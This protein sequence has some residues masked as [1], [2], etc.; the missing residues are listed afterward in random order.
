MSRLGN[1]KGINIFNIIIPS[2]IILLIALYFIGGYRKS[3]DEGIFD[4]NKVYQHIKELSSPKYKGRLAGDEGNKLTLQYIE[5]YFKN[6]GIEPAGKNDTYYQYFDTMITHIDLNPY[7]AIESKD[8]QIIEEFEMFKDYKFFT[9]WYGG[10][11]RFK[12]DIVFVDNYLYDVPPQLLKNKLVVMGTFDIRIKDV[13]YVIRNNGKG[14]LFRRTSPYDRQDRELQ[15]QKKVENTIKKGESLFFG[16]LGLEAYNKIKNYSSHELINQGMSEDILVEE[17]LPESVGIIKNVKLKCDINYPVIKTANILGKIDGKAKDK[18]LIIGANIDH[19]GQGMNGKHFPGALNN[20]SGTGMMLEL[21]RV[22]KLQK[23]LPDRTIIFAGWNAKENVAAGSQYYVKNPLSPLEK[24]QV[25]N[26][27]CIGSTVDGEIRFETKGEAGEILRDKIIQ[28]AEDLKDTNNLQIETIKTPVGRWSD[29]MPFIET[30][31]P[32]INIIDG[33]LNLYTYEDNIDNVS[34]EKLKKVGI[35]IINY[36]KREIFKDT[37]ADYLNNI[38]IILIIIFLFGTLFIYMIFSIYKTNGDM[39]ILSISI[40]NIYYSLPFNILLKCFYFIT[41]AFII[42]FS[43]IFIG[44]LPLNFNMVFHNGELYT[45][46]SMYL[47]MKKSILY[48]RNLLLHGF[49]MTE[50]NVEIFRIVLNSTGKSVKLLSFAIVISLILGVVKGMFDSYKGGRRSG[51]RTVGTL[52]A[53]SLPD[54]FIVLCSMLL[55]SYISYSDMIKQLV[56]LSKLKGFFMPLL[57]LSIIPTV[58]ISRITFIVVQEEI[59]KD[60]V[61]AAKGRG[62]SKF[63]IFTRHILKSVVI[64]VVDSIP[65]LITIIISNLIIVE[66]L[67]DYRGIVFNLYRF[68]KQNDINSFIGLSLALGLIYITFIIIAKLISRLINP[69]KREGVN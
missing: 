25:I 39:E 59:K 53:F 19:V 17:E 10:G 16:Y 46:F 56:D 51:L 34:K 1:F 47:T 64:K 5:D 58:Y 60:Y 11:G 15:L 35:V 62:L 12:G 55:I 44:S 31:I 37:L 32:A 61:I 48:I 24:T 9:Y 40:E 22:I 50:N 36:I 69:K 68:Y 29:H 23:N 66:Y 20:A 13:E 57:T 7:F 21:A 2:L 65:A 18:Y 3:F 67:L 38:E 52:M 54:V 63:N 28:Y 8:G 27:D 49:G 4:E 43:L 14:I 41:P 30:K 26:L 33:S 6:L 42:L 45:N